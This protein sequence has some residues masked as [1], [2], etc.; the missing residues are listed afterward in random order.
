[1]SENTTTNTT[2][3]EAVVSAVATVAVST[4]EEKRVDLVAKIETKLA[5]SDIGTKNKILYNLYLTL[6]KTAGDALMEK[7]VAKI[8]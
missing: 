8:S 1:M 5:E 4:L 2:I 7:I 6:I 3:T